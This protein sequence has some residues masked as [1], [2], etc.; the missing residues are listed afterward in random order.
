LAAVWLGRRHGVNVAVVPASGRMQP[1]P[2]AGEDMGEMTGMA[3]APVCSRVRGIQQIQHKMG[4][5]E[6]LPLCGESALQR[7]RFGGHTHRCDALSRNQ[8]EE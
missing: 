6:R 8:R 2:L 1:Q 5:V 4:A 3:G 7:R